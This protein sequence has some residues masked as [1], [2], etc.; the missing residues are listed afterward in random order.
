MPDGNPAAIETPA[1]LAKAGVRVVAA[2]PEVPITKY[3]TEVLANLAELE[4]YPDGFAEA[5]TANTVSE[6]E[7]VRAVLAK[8]ELGEGDAALVYVTDAL[9]SEGVDTVAIPDDAN[10]LVTYAAVTVGASSQPALAADFLEFLVGPEAQA[11]L[12]SDGFVPV[13]GAPSESPAP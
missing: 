8:I 2:L 6:E 9:S 11:V 13:A 12:A 1:D 3:T 5:V 10:V 4:G 7:N